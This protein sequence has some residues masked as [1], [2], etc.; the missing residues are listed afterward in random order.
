[1]TTPDT[2]IIV[3]TFVVYMAVCLMLA[4]LLGLWLVWS[5]TFGGG[6]DQSE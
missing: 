1:M 4:T 3:A 6:H 2:R 5:K